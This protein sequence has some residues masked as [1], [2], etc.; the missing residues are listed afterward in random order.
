MKSK[1]LKRVAGQS[2]ALTTV[3]AVVTALFSPVYAQPAVTALPTGAQVV[4]GSAA[5]NT[6]GASMQIQ[7]NSAKL[8]TNWQNFDIGSAAKVEFV[9][10]S[11]ASIALNRVTGSDAA[12]QIFGVLNANGRVFLVNPNGIL[13]GATARIDAGSLVASTLNIRDQD[14][15]AGQYQFDL[16]NPVGQVKNFGELVAKQG[17]F[18]ALMGAQVD[19]AG[20]VVATG[21]QAALAAG[22]SVRMQIGET[23]LLGMDVV[24]GQT[25][26]QVSNSGAVIAHGG[27][28]L[29][30]AQSAAGLMS[31]AVNLTGLVQ[32]SRIDGQGGHVRLD[33]GEIT[34]SQSGRIEA[35]GQGTDV[36]LWS[37]RATRMDGTINAWG[38]RVETSSKGALGVTGQVQAQEWVLDPHSLSV[39]NTVTDNTSQVAA[40][41]IQNSLNA[42]TSIVLEASGDA[43]TA[44]TIA[45]NADISKTAGAE[46]TLT[47]RTHDYAAG[48]NRQDVN[49]VIN[50]PISSIAGALNIQFGGSSTDAGGRVTLNAPL[51]TN[52]GDVI[53]FK[54]T[55][56]AHA[57]PISTKITENSSAQSGNIIFEKNTLLA[58][59]GYA[60][61]LDTQG[62]QSGGSY[63]GQGGN[64]DIKANIFSAKPTNLPQYAQAL[65]LDTT[66]YNGANALN[67]PGNI[68]LGSIAANVVGG[69]NLTPGSVDA[70]KSLTLLGD[71][72]VE[73]KANT[74]NIVSSN[75]DVITGSSRLGTPTLLLNADN[76]TINVYGDRQGNLAGNVAG[77]TD[78]VQ[79]TFDIEGGK[80]TAQTLTVNSDRAI[81]QVNRSITAGGAGKLDVNLN[82][83]RT[84]GSGL[85]GVAMTN[86]TVNTLGGHF[87]VAG[88]VGNGGDVQLLT[89]GFYASNSQIVT[90]GGALTITA[91]APT[92][93]AAG[94][95]IRLTGASTVLSSGSGNM[96]LTGSVNNFAGSGN[97][98]AV[99]IGEGGNARVTLTATTGDI[100]ITGNASGVGSG[101]LVTGGSRYNGVVIS[102]KAL[103]ETTGNTTGAD[104]GNITIEGH[105]GGGDK[106]FISENHGVRFADADT[107]VVSTTGNIAVVGKS[108]GKT[109]GTSGTNSFGIYAEGQ[110]IYVGSK[111]ADYA[112]AGNNIGLLTALPSSG[113][114]VTLAADSMQFVNTS[115]SH[116]KVASQGELRIHTLNA[117]TAIEIGATTGELATAQNSPTQYLGSNWFNGTPNAIFQ[118][119]FR[120]VVIGNARSSV[121]HVNGELATVGSTATMK[122]SSAT[123]FRDN[124]VL[125]MSGIGGQFVLAANAP[126]TVSAGSVGTLGKPNSDGRSLTVQTQAGATATESLL[127]VDQLQILGSG[128]QNF[129]RA[130]GHQ[131]NTLAARLSAGDLTLNNNQDLTVGS[132]SVFGGQNV[133]PVAH[134]QKNTWMDT[135]A[136]G[137]KGPGARTQLVG[138]N[139]TVPTVGI[140]T[141]GN[142]ILN[143]ENAH[144][145]QTDAG[146]IRANKLT[147]TAATHVDF[148]KAD[149][150]GT[151]FEANNVVHLAG[152]SNKGDF[153]WK[154]IDGFNIDRLSTLS[155]QGVI[156]RPDG[157]QG[158]TID[159]QALSGDITQGVSLQA[160]N[161]RAQAQNNVN[162][163]NVGNL[164]ENIS[165]K[166]TAGSFAYTDADS[167]RLASA[168]ATRSTGAETHGVTAAITI[169]LRSVA[170]ALSQTVAGAVNAVN[171]HAS[172]ATGVVLDTAST[173][174]VAN[175]SGAVT[176]VGD[177]VYADTNALTVGTVADVAGLTVKSGHVSLVSGGALS[178]TSAG[179]IDTQGLR[180]LAATGGVHLDHANNKVQ[181]LAGTSTAG[182][183]VFKNNDGFRVGT[184][185]ADGVR[186]TSEGIS[187]SAQVDLQANA[188]NISQTAAGG[189]TGT[190]LRAV[191][192]GGVWLATADD[193]NVAQIAGQASAGHF[194]FKDT[195]GD[196]QV[197]VAGVRVINNGVMARDTVD[198][199][200]VSGALSQGQSI[201]GSALRAQAS[202][203]VTLSNAN[204]HVTKLAGRSTNGDFTYVD[205]GSVTV[206][207]VAAAQDGQVLTAGIQAKTMGKTVHLQAAN[208]LGQEAGASVMAPNALL[209]AAVVSLTERNNE[210][211]VLA[212][213]SDGNFTFF[214]TSD[215]SVGTVNA[216]SGVDRRV[217]GGT[218]LAKVDIQTRG[219]LTLN[220][221]VKGRVEGN[222]AL[223]EAVVLRAEKRFLNA[224]SLREQ[225]IVAD[226]GRWL[227]YDNNPLLL[228]KD[229]NGLASGTVN[230]TSD[231][232]FL[233]INTRFQ[234]YTP[235]SVYAKGNGYI[236]TAQALNPEDVVRVTAGHQS[237]ALGQQAREVTPD[238]I[239]R[240]TKMNQ[241]TGVTP[242]VLTGARGS[243]AMISS[244]AAVPLRVA[245]PMGRAFKLDL[246]D[247]VGQGR[248]STIAAADGSATPWVSAAGQAELIGTA[249][250][251]TE[252][253]LSIM[254]PGQAQPRSIRLQLQPL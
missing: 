243:F 167:L 244:G 209:N 189:I 217:V 245:V 212:G 160:Q 130:D 205:A 155:T 178:Q 106:V 23:G 113:G 104:A 253:V 213:R 193:N 150:V 254:D 198:L 140:H 227:V 122:V 80:A 47:F 22:Q 75:G 148:F 44:G 242:T 123:T 25:N 28:V 204:N 174:N 52:G 86:A 108:G 118:P 183:F 154:D 120:D 68:I 82:P 168:K 13:F 111:A 173:N 186:L 95:A 98:D 36:M 109:K 46:A 66:G 199:N 169:D 166:A 74:V 162:L 125:D 208:L 132:V 241:L 158:H 180:A 87:I 175:L 223:D 206:A 153:A 165:G 135:V 71:K 4:H 112:T 157:A 192:P 138:T 39:V 127:T 2:F 77:Y 24:A 226:G 49:V 45:V 15:L 27:N 116:M 79:S 72:V 18:V 142:V 247:L 216:V 54:E 149:G 202:G 37:D 239:E 170:G 88:A 145:T 101:D 182:D 215:L 222:E 143:S 136:Q 21:G 172:A 6:I 218:A 96:T 105:G 164:V 81:K 249:P 41:S 99:V 171:L 131:I 114:H 151:Q 214:N 40:S 63:T 221:P 32:A 19:N 1:Q 187:A 100:S 48:Q 83:N 38:G 12:S 5:I 34:M 179:V 26:T 84:N 203:N 219:N 89:D 91:V 190:S 159:L 139:T 129:S 51:A 107:S 31:G 3:A 161:L 200:V 10:P 220:D 102:S 236:T 144:L 97:K 7:Q 59:P 61:S 181:T 252:L 57:T 184:V 56:L 69:S 8:I 163:S 93:T 11:A 53:F 134:N 119:G 70:I 201:T 156:A 210:V 232:D 211:R 146:G 124:V 67:G 224:T 110:N 231:R 234:D 50:N 60:V 9:Q 55:V 141:P 64:I 251:A 85:G 176:G 238:Q 152:V 126:L 58:A 233:L 235:T 246:R 137:A 30:S 92:D 33:G 20:R 248:V 250:K 94:S 117:G 42:G 16:N 121:D 207:T 191:A 62:P 197:N 188:S 128:T 147:A 73:L 103:I 177:F 229:M 35:T 228:N 196:L 237:S 65:T 76:T 14:F 29:M 195:G 78:F 43:V 240:M 225:A 194:A 115:A 90:G 17:G 185:T 230:V 133:L